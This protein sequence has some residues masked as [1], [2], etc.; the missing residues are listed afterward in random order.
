MDMLGK[1]RPHIHAD[2]D[3]LDAKSGSEPQFVFSYLRHLRQVGQI[4][5]NFQHTVIDF[6]GKYNATQFDK[7]VR[8][9]QTGKI[10]QVKGN[11]CIIGYQK[12]R[13]HYVAF[14]KV[15][16]KWYMHDSLN[17][18]TQQRSPEE[19]MQSLKQKNNQHITLSQAD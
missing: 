11:R 18:V 14:T 10:P 5:K 3:V 12:P 15:T 4:P 2:L 6:S 17:P 9:D 13:Q 8:I 1:A 7:D 19:F 16:G